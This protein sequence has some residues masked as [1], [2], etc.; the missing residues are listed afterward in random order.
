[1]NVETRNVLQAI[2]GNGFEVDVRRGGDSVGVLVVDH[3]RRAESSFSFSAANEVKVV[4]EI[5]RCF[6]SVNQRTAIFGDSTP[7][8]ANGPYR[9]AML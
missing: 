2:R 7:V 5:A 6:C 4:D 9:Y 1:M 3:R 8:A